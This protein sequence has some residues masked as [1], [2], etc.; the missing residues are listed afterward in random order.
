M[1][2]SPSLL[3]AAI[4]LVLLVV[5]ACQSTTEGPSPS[6]TP[7]TAVEAETTTSPSEDL[8]PTE[9][10]SSP[11]PSLETEAP[12]PLNRLLE[13]RSV[14]LLLTG[15]RPDGALRSIAVQTDAVGNQ[16]VVFTSPAFNPSETLE[17][18]TL[19]EGDRRYEVYVI[20]NKAYAPSDTDPGW[21]TQPTSEDYFPQLSSQ[22][23]NL[24][25]FTTWLDLLPNG[26]LLPAGTEETGGFQ[27]DKYEVSGLI[28]D[29]AV[30]GFL[31]YDQASHSLIKAEI[32]VPAILDSGLLEPA[33]GDILI[34]LSAENK[35][36]PPIT[37][38]EGVSE[39]ETLVQPTLD[40]A[41][42]VYAAGQPVVANT[43][44]V[45]T[46]YPDNKGGGISVMLAL[47]GQVWTGSMFG[48]LQLWDPASGAV[49]K[50]ISA[51]P[52]MM[53]YDIESDG[54]QLWVL[55][56]DDL[57]SDGPDAVYVLSL[58]EGEVTARFDLASGSG[59]EQLGVSPGR[60]W[61]GDTVY[62]T[63]TLQSSPVSSG[64]PSEARFAYDGEQ[65]MWI[66]GVYCHGCNH[67]LWLF[68]AENLPD[69]K[70]DQN[71]GTLRDGVLGSQP[72]L[73]AGRMWL[74]VRPN[75][76]PIYWLDAY[77]LN[78]TSQPVLQIDVSDIFEETDTQSS[79]V[80]LAADNQVLWM[81]LNEKL[82]YFDL[83]TG[84]QLG[85]LPVGA[86]VMGMG[87]DGVNLWLLS[88]TEGLTRIS[89]PWEE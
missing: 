61:I 38:P 10:A 67:D 49:V 71:S 13:L 34:T 20:E 40:M 37:L 89:I 12:D 57:E 19:P 86:D 74:V 36:I 47:P 80:Y 52:S 70:D 66:T 63:S 54:E 73:A 3:L 16:Q 8:A 21:M 29:Q 26:S 42:A 55:A 7:L 31:W 81:S 33:E 83:A 39:A 22:M 35:V 14:S 4:L 30:T 76:D 87:F 44:P 64:L 23:H 88:N 17:G 43:Y 6:P 69:H 58:P 5:S 46:L 65:Y 41:N 2:R 15:T 50:T 84:Q 72:V 9:T 51:V 1:K 28:D 11:S 78:N 79:Q 32:R 82:A 62:D 18:L 56:S 77:D 59:V 68:D 85:S 25:G 53:F 45:Q 60:V 24:E 48:G 27:S 75:G